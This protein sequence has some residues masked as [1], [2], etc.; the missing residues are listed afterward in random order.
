M[1][2]I[3]NHFGGDGMYLVLFCAWR[4]KKSLDSERI[5]MLVEWMDKLPTLTSDGYELIAKALG[6]AGRKES[7]LRYAR[8]VRPTKF[9]AGLDIKTAFDEAKSKHVAQILTTT[10]RID[11]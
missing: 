4:G 2:Y 1:T 3:C 11:G 5:C 10:T 7:V 6:M 9:L 8:V